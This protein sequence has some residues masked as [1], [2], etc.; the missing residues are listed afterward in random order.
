MAAMQAQ[1]ASNVQT[2]MADGSRI[3][4]S[5]VCHGTEGGLARTKG[6]VG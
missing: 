1:A 4:D 5:E 6:G 2:T 3:D